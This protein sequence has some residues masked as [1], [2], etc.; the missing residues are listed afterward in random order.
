[1]GEPA[2][3]RDRHIDSQ[4]RRSPFEAQER[5]RTRDA[6][7]GE[8]VVDTWSKPPKRPRRRG[9]CRR[10]D[11]ELIKQKRKQA[12]L[13]H[14]EEDDETRTTRPRTTRQGRVKTSSST[15]DVRTLWAPWRMEYIQRPGADSIFCDFAAAPPTPS[16]ISSSSWFSRTR[17][18]PSTSIR[19]RRRT[20]SWRRGARRR[21]GDLRPEEYGTRPL[22][23]CVKRPVRVRV[24]RGP[25]G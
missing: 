25:R 1:V 7:R 15:G 19:L 17:F 23:P 8:A 21:V 9:G 10:N 22:R 20:C 4:E 2:R 18:V 6:R 13:D 16:A 11:R 3:G 12:R 14:T 5:G 24:R